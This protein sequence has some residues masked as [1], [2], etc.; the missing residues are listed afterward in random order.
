MT[1]QQ[2]DLLKKEYSE[3]EAKHKETLKLLEK[4]DNYKKFQWMFRDTRYRFKLIKWHLSTKMSPKSLLRDLNRASL[5]YPSGID[6]RPVEIFGINSWGERELIYSG[7]N[8]YDYIL[9]QTTNMWSW[10]SK[11][12]SA[13]AE[14]ERSA[15]RE[16]AKLRVKMEEEEE[17]KRA[18]AED[19]RAGLS[20]NQM[21]LRSLE[22]STARMNQYSQRIHAKIAEGSAGLGRAADNITDVARQLV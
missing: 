13:L 6:P 11:A 16:A 8:L 1:Q 4:F 21:L 7:E 18:T 22:R 19:E 14:A 2:S 10:N 17:E 9:H 3:I 15:V 12:E 5:M 20:R